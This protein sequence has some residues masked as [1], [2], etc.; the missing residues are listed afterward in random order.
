MCNSKYYNHLKK[1]NLNCITLCK[2][3]QCFQLLFTHCIFCSIFWFACINLSIYCYYFFYIIINMW[4]F[5]FCY[6]YK[7][8]APASN[9]T[10]TF[11]GYSV[12]D[13][14]GVIFTSYILVLV[15]MQ[16]RVL[17]NI[18]FSNYRIFYLYLNTRFYYDLC[19]ILTRF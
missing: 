5:V 14:N 18:V 8:L 7:N 17:H 12:L 13:E 19:N 11:I 2:D 16:F 6:A 10:N 4:Y 3:I 15:W 1:Q 9:A